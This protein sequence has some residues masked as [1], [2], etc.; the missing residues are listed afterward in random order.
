MG[1]HLL[2]VSLCGSV[3]VSTKLDPLLDP[4]MDDPFFEQWLS[5]PHRLSDELYVFS[6]DSSCNEI[7]R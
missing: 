2:D 4:H 6:N 3:W 5:Q 7:F 1:I